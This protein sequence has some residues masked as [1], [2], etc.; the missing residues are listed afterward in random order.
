MPNDTH[1][2][3]RRLRLPLVVALLCG[4]VCLG[5]ESFFR[6]REAWR[7][8][9]LSQQ[10]SIIARGHR[11][12]AT[13]RQALADGAAQ[14][15]AVPLRRAET[16]VILA[17]FHAW[18]PMLQEPPALSADSRARHAR[19]AVAFQ[20][21]AAALQPASRLRWELLLRYAKLAGDRGTEHRARQRLKCLQTNEGKRAEPRMRDDAA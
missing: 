10:L 18:W 7:A 6:V 9:A 15:A 11:P 13:E 19:S 17:N 1:K 3:F 12:E 4:S 8:E 5:H 16:A 14:L 2:A 21:Q 20:V